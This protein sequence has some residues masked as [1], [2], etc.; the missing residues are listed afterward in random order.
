[1]MGGPDGNSPVDRYES[2]PRYIGATNLGAATGTIYFQ[3][4]TAGFAKS[5]SQFDVWTFSA[6]PSGLTKYRVGLYSVA[7]NGD[8]TLVAATADIKA[9]LT[10]AS[11]H[12]T[13]ALALAGDLTT[14]QL[15]YNLVAGQRYAFAEIAT[16]TTS[17]SYVGIHQQFNSIAGMS[18]KVS[19]SYAGQTELVTPVTNANAAAYLGRHY[20]SAQ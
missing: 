14:A 3:Y 10:G 15:T 7:A 1:M 20:L 11:L 5:I 16:G 8:L 13:P 17:C 18:P 19:A 12:L 2:F 6:V 9:T 4:F